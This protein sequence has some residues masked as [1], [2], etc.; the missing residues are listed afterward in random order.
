MQAQP[1]FEA[2]AF[3]DHLVLIVFA[4]AL[5]MQW[6]MHRVT[7]RLSDWRI[8]LPVAFTAAVWAVI[9]W[10]IG[11]GQGVF[12]GLIGIAFS[13]ALAVLDERTRQERDSRPARHR[14]D[15]IRFG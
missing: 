11:G 10:V 7:N 9:G 15:G 14:E 12:T 5:A 8:V 6:V 1:E 4:L 2:A 13:L 3:A